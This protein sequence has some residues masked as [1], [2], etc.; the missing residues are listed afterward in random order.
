[1][2]NYS[3]AKSHLLSSGSAGFAEPKDLNLRIK[4]D[5]SGIPCFPVADRRSLAAILLFTPASSQE[6]YLSQSTSLLSS[7]APLPSSN[8]APLPA[9]P[10]P[11]APHRSPPGASQSCPCTQ[12]PSVDTYTASQ[13]W[14]LHPWCCAPCTQS[15]SSPPPQC[16]S[17]H[18]FRRCLSTL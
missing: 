8:R 12:C 14:A 16:P 3:R 7:P 6:L 5:S 18:R 4:H 2:N 17:P 10:A 1:F 9:A 15:T 13:S 11:R